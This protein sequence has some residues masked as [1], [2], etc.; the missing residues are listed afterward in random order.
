MRTAVAILACIA[1]V[2]GGLLAG[3]FT[4][5][6][7]LSGDAQAALLYAA[8]FSFM[9]CALY[10]LTTSSRILSTVIAAIAGVFVLALIVDVCR[11]TQRDGS[12]NTSYLTLHFVSMVG[13]A[14]ICIDQI[15]RARES[16]RQLAS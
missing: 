4:V 12:F 5:L 16:R 6:L 14:L 1:T 15:F 10:S 3:F 9:G 13:A 7:A 2:F 8:E 11:V